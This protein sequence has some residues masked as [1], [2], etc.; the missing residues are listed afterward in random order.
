MLEKSLVIQ[1]NSDWSAVVK[2]NPNEAL[3]YN[4]D[5]IWK[6]RDMLQYMPHDIVK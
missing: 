3:P 2:H 5:F 1:Y 4:D 6:Y